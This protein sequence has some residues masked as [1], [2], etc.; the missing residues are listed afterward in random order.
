M[1]TK[2]DIINKAYA[3]M[4]I[5]GLTVEPTP[6]DTALALDR[7]E[8][9]AASWASRYDIDYDFEEVPQSTTPHMIPRRHW[10]AFETCLAMELIPDFGKE[11]PQQLARLANA[12]YSRLTADYHRTK[13]VQYPQRQPLGSGTARK[14]YRYTTFYKTSTQPL[15]GAYAAYTNDIND[16]EENFS[17]YL[18]YGED[19]SSYVLTADSKLT[20]LSESLATPVVSYQLRFD[21]ASELE[22]VIITITTS[23][24]R[25]ETR[26][27]QFVIRDADSAN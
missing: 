21:E 15:A 23:T 14:F 27:K 3:R 17:D 20:V 11:V 2:I 24:G 9:M 12:A 25:K 6:E 8:S 19:I 26:K 10:A 1:S 7:L 4:R 13:I 22:E 16:F 5:S 18:E